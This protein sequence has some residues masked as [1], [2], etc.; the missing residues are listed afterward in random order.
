[1]PLAAQTQTSVSS[2]SNALFERNAHNPDLSRKHWPNPVHSSINSPEWKSVWRFALYRFVHIWYGLPKYCCGGNSTVRHIRGNAV[3]GGC[4]LFPSV[5]T[6]S[7]RA[8]KAWIEPT[9]PRWM[10]MP[11]SQPRIGRACDECW[12]PWKWL[13]Q[14]ERTWCGSSQMRQ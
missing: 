1:M 6:W 3:P 2:T 5:R 9:Q 11:H 13:G 10:A 14:S 4:R 8:L 12:K 7:G